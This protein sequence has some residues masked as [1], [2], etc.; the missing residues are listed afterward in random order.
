VHETCFTILTGRGNAPR[1]PTTSPAAKSGATLS[2]D[3][4]RRVRQT[5]EAFVYFGN[6]PRVAF[7]SP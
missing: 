2:N 7:N 3:S 1:P 6:N 4:L 5:E